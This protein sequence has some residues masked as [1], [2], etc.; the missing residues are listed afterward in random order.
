MKVHL[1]CLIVVLG[2][3]V[4]LT[5]PAAG[6]PDT[7]AA[8]GRLQLDAHG[9]GAGCEP[10]D[11]CPVL[12]LDA[13]L[14]RV[15]RTGP[16]VQRI[17]LE[18]DRAAAELQEARGG[19]DPQL[20]SG[21][22]Y[23]TQAGGDK[24]NVLRTGVDVPLNLPLSPSVT[25]DYRRGLGSSIDPSVKTTFD[26][27]TSFGLAFEPLDAFFLDKKQA[28]LSKARLEPRRAD[29]LQAGARNDLLLEA[30]RAYL[31]WVEAQRKL[32]ISR[33]LLDLA[34]RR[35][36]L[37]TRQ[38]ET[39]EAA[40]IDSTEAKLAVA[41]RRE[42]VAADEQA[43]RGAGVKVATFLWTAEGR[44]ASFA[45]APPPSVPIPDAE[46]A[47]SERATQ[48]ALDRR[49][50]LRELDVKLQ[51]TR[52]QQR[53]ARERLRPNLKLKAQVVSYENGPADVTDVKVGFEIRQPLFF[54]GAR[55]EAEEVRI[56]AQEVSL[57]RDE[58]RRKVRADVEAALIDLRQARRRVDA[59]EEQ[60]SLARRLAE[61]EQR[62]FE[63][64]ESTLFLVNQREQG[65]AKA[66]K[67][68]ATARVDLARAYATYR[69]AT[70]T[71]ADAY[72]VN[73]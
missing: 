28:T 27:E 17:R 2:L 26:G 64:G 40:A 57:K 59:A 71:I 63:I 31:K 67:A 47:T 37:V 70:G 6:Q 65:F 41:S 56:D 53:L 30:T 4:G 1:R 11:E 51:Q 44:P 45:F 62:R 60:V 38:A 5:M 61:A 66:R 20:S 24:I 25:A 14:G 21:Y 23:K 46:V 32:A 13:F 15:L 35:R 33:D 69:W 22:E 19:F 29:A 55:S 9:G 18:D 43:F 42:E 52:I 58:T 39:G 54:R 72:G 49:P 73:R 7:T 8:S 50:E 3:A 10:E 34:M 16:P 48:V 68:L 36:V 12:E